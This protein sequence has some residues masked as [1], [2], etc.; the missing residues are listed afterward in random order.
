MLLLPEK[1]GGGD[2][3]L[4]AARAAQAFNERR[5]GNR[6]LFFL[7]ASRGRVV[8]SQPYSVGGGIH[9]HEG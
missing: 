1:W 7:R 4:G 3:T 5:A 9:I 6:S 2:H 8:T